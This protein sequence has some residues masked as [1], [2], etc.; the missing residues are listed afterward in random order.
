MTPALADRATRVK[1]RTAL[2]SVVS[3]SALVALKL[4][5]GLAIGSVAVISEAIHSGIDLLA[6]LIAWYAVR[7]SDTPPD[8][9]HP[10]GHGK[11]ES[12]SGTIEAL[13][14]F[15]AG[16]WVIYEAVMGLLRGKSATTPLWGVAVMGISAVVNTFIARRLHK[17]A[18]EFDSVALR[19]DAHHLSVD[20]YTSLGVFA[21]LG[22]VALTGWH[23]LDSVAAIAVGLL[24][25]HTAYGITKQSFEPLVDAALPPEE[26]ERIEAALRSSEPVRGWHNLR[27]RKAGSARFVDFHLLLDDDLSLAAAHDITHEVKALVE[28]ALPGALVDIHTEPFEGECLDKGDVITLRI[29]HTGPQEAPVLMGLPDPPIL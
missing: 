17:V 26:I 19:A 28:A 18:D 8:R 20:V 9:E 1:S 24:I 22:L 6:S 14:I 3:N 23:A 16:V 4:A 27:T 2:L 15:I 25:L 12:I 21:G 7:V 29:P 13:L 11:I 5:V 10:Y